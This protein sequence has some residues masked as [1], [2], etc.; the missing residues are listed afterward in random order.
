MIPRIGWP[1]PVSAIRVP[2]N[3]TPADKGFGPVDRVEHPDELGILAHP[4]ELLAD[5]PVLRKVALDQVAH[6]HF[7][8]AVCGGHRAQIGLVVYRERLAEIRSDRPPR[9]V[10]QFGGE[11]QAAVE[12]GGIHELISGSADRR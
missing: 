8:G 5:D 6:R 7:G 10:G 9:R 3:G 2:N 11:R 1:L 4:A 12:G